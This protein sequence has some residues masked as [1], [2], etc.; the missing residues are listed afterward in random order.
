MAKIE[1]NETQKAAIVSLLIEMIN[2]D[3]VVE[4]CECTV[5]DTICVEY[6]INAIM[7]PVS[8]DPLSA[9]YAPK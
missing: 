8:I 1:F 7:S 6:C 2:A 3:H 9:S 5:F 4:D